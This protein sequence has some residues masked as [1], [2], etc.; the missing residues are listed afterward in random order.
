MSTTSDT[1]MHTFQFQGVTYQQAS[2]TAMHTFQLQGVIAQTIST[3][4]WHSNAHFPVAGCHRTKHFN[5]E[6]TQQ[7]LHPFQGVLTQSNMS[8]RSDTAMH[9]FQF[10][11]VTYQH[12][13]GTAMHTTCR[14]SSHKTF[15]QASD[16]TMHNSSCR[17][18]SH[19]TC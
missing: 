16:T 15:Q 10:Q 11:G 1:A 8:T 18:S 5:K 4:K 2:D 6:V 9:A 7:C 13:S 17:V 19:K 12:A 14:V 3:R